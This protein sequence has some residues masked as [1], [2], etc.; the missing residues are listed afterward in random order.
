M[1]CSWS[2]PSSASGAL[3]THISYTKIEQST[4]GMWRCEGSARSERSLKTGT[5][6]QPFT[7]AWETNSFTS[8]ALCA[9]V[10]ANITQSRCLCVT[11]LPQPNSGALRSAARHVSDPV[12]E[13]TRGPVFG[14]P[15][16]LLVPVCA[17]CHRAFP[18]QNPAGLPS[19][20][21]QERRLC[22]KFQDIFS[23]SRNVNNWTTIGCWLILD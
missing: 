1:L 13:V 12:W 20:E 18:L 19:G 9:S 11:P 2:G 15:L 7:S 16:H 14:G 6:A 5:A 8:C 22:C 23:P 3:R 10:S 17:V 4:W 21:T